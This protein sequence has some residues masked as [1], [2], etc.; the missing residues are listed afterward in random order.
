M[1]NNIMPEKRLQ[2]IGVWIIVLVILSLIIK[3]SFYLRSIGYDHI[4]ETFVILDE[5]TNV[6]HGL[7]LRKSGIPAAWS[8]LESYK[9][10]T[11][12]DISGLNLSVN[13]NNPNF[14]SFRDFPKPVFV[15]SPIYF[16]VER[17]LKHI[18]FVQPYLDHP[19]FGALVL[20][21]F[22]SSKIET[23]SD[24]TPF[25]FRKG[26]LWLGIATGIL[27]FILG[28]QVFNNP[29][30]GLLATAIYGSIPT[31]ILLSR[32][33]LLENVLNP[34]MLLSINLLVFAQKLT[35]SQRKIRPLNLKTLLFL[36][37]VAAGLTALIKITGWF[38]LII[39]FVLLLY[40]KVNLKTSLFFI[41]PAVLVG[42]F[43]FVWGLYLAQGLFLDVFRYQS[44]ERGFIGSINFL[45]TATRVGI[46]NF[47]LDGWWVG[48]FLS[49]ILLPFKKQYS[50]ILFSALIVLLIA[51]FFGGANYPWYFIPMI[52]F[53]CLATAQFFWQ[54]ATNPKFIT[55]LIF[56]LIF[57][58]STF[59]WGYGVFQASLEATNYQ[60]PY[61]LY[62]IL[63]IFFI[64][65]GIIFS[66]Q[67]KFKKLKYLWFIFMIL[68]TLILIRLN[69]RSLYFILSNW[70]KFPSLYIPGTF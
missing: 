53:I 42:L 47:P 12:G 32:Y 6:W 48:G 4:P 41:I 10:G 19:P 15:L 17:G 49:L 8:N 51:L 20:S 18:E 56:F 2:R 63:L 31:F 50:S 25:D 14:A 69:E 1:H 54:V 45:V 16:G 59:Y 60:Q 33:A 11:G 39:G 70:G 37:G 67:Y 23:F 5:R 27:I 38:V 46:L 24:L 62:R 44:I 21:V 61:F 43:Y 22:V 28:W 29:F 52:P 30:I 57:V 55:I 13:Q 35:N 36:A 64:L 66:I 3:H 26:S 68:T 7:S 65:S 34:F 40:W 58:S 9:K